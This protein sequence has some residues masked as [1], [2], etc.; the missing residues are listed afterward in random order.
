MAAVGKQT[1]TRVP[2]PRSLSI[3]SA[4]PCASTMCY[5]AVNRALSFCEMTGGV[6]GRQNLGGGI[7]TRPAAGVP[8]FQM[9][10]A[11]STVSGTESHIQKK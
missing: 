3:R 5:A 9:C 4:P 7:I 1:E 10:V 11:R 2:W 8:G 6:G